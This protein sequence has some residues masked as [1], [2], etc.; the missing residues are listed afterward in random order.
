MGKFRKGQSGN[1]NGRPKSETLNNEELRRKVRE[2]L[3]DILNP[4]DLKSDFDKITK[5]ELKFKIRCDFAKMLL[6]DP[7][8][9]DKMS[10]EQMNEI[11]DYL[12]RKQYEEASN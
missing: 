2:F 8:N 9:P 3:S 4:D 7:V 5:P 6:P 12:K 1:P 10:L 11:I